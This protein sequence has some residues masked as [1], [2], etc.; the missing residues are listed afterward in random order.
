MCTIIYACIAFAQPA[1][2]V[3]PGFMQLIPLGEYKYTLVFAW[4]AI[5]VAFVPINATC[6]VYS[7]A[8]SERTK[9]FTI[10]SNF[11]G[12]FWCRAWRVSKINMYARFWPCKSTFYFRYIFEI[13]VLMKKR[14]LWYCVSSSKI[15]IMYHN[16]R[17]K[18]NHVNLY[19]II[20]TVP[21]N[22]FIATPSPASNLI[23]LFH[24]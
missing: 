15:A 7:Y 21:D 2:T 18:F 20:S 13:R 6:Y 1:A 4:H 5:L 3:A 23:E 19:K 11:G 10:P 16:I 9:I 8:S 12:P 24:L 22:Q 14:M 17:L